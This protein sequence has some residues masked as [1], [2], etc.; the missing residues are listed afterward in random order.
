MIGNT[1][2][3]TEVS[4]F[5]ACRAHD[6]CWSTCAIDLDFEKHRKSCDDSFHKNLIAACD[7]AIDK[8][9]SQ[10]RSAEAQRQCINHANSYYQYVKMFSSK[11]YF[12]V[13][14]SHCELCI[15]DS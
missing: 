13:Q 7:I 1:S 11:K 8:K 10:W 14:L 9:V 2:Y 5:D 4:F 15:D 6:L 3:I 12:E